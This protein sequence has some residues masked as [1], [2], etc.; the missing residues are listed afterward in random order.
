MGMPAIGENP[1]GMTGDGDDDFQLLNMTLDA[2]IA[3][4][5]SLLSSLPDGMSMDRCR[6]FDE[7][8]GG[9]GGGTIESTNFHISIAHTFMKLSAKTSSIPFSNVD[10][11]TCR[12]FDRGG[13][14]GGDVSTATSAV[15]MRGSIDC[16]QHPD[17]TM[18]RANTATE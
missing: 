7:F 10:D 16:S 13:G 15:V 2:G 12:C 18:L 6:V 3:T 14:G 8:F 17:P 11:T 4:S 1:M 5:S 9:G